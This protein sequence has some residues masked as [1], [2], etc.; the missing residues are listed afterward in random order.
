MKLLPPCWMKVGVA[1][2]FGLWLQ[3]GEKY[4]SVSFI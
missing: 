3:T 1:R 2:D 4:F